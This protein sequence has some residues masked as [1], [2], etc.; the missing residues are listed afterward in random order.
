LTA[1]FSAASR[2]WALVSAITMATGSPTWRTLPS[3]SI[4]CLGSTIGVLFLP[5]TSQPQ[6]M[7][8][9]AFTSSPV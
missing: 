1:I 7:P 8:L 2:A 5:V 6:G 9:I 3:A 4:G